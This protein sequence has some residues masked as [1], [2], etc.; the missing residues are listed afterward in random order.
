MI[1]A[2]IA[3][4]KANKALTGVSS[5]SSVLLIMF[6]AAYIDQDK[7]IN[8]MSLELGEKRAMSVYYEKALIDL[9]ELCSK[10]N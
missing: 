6:A 1:Q 3:L 9:T 7:T 5:A 10:E 8:K 4:L 2:C